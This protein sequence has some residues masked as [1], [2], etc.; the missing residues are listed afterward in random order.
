MLIKYHDKLCDATNTL[1]EGEKELDIFNNNDLED[2][3][4]FPNNFLEDT[5]E[6]DLKEILEAS[7]EDK[8]E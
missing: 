2:T 6:I 8:N 1:E 7:K 4:E 3:M 5:I